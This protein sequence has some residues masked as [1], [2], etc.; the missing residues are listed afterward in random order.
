MHLMFCYSHE[1]KQHLVRFNRSYF[2]NGFP[3]ARHEAV[4]ITECR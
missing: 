4:L 1:G 2:A 3:N